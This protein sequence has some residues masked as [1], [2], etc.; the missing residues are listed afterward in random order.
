MIDNDLTIRKKIL[1]IDDNEAHLAAAEE[2]LKDEYDIFK[3]S[4]GQEAFQYLFRFQLEVDLIMLDIVMPDMDGW[5]VFRWLRSASTLEK[6]PVL[7]LTSL[8]AEED[9]KKA[10]ELGAV[11]YV[12]KPYYRKFL[13]DTIKRIFS[14][15]KGI[16]DDTDD[17]AGAVDI[18]ELE[19]VPAAEN[20]KTEE[21]K[22]KTVINLS[23]LLPD[24]FS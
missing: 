22:S 5:E 8:N 15:G 13:K 11:D 3:A 23:E 12:T 18:E 24:S 17:M 19:E 21:K 9:K 2:M 1:I 6:I 16:T 20:K 10:R 14:L 7:F 4:S